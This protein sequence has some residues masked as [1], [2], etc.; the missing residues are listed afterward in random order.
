[1][2]ATILDDTNHIIINVIIVDAVGDLGTV[3]YES[4]HQPNQQFTLEDGVRAPVLPDPIV[5]P[6]AELEN[7]LWEAYRS[8]QGSHLT[9]D[10]SSMYYTER[11]NSPKAQA[12]IDWKDNVWTQYYIDKGT[13]NYSPNFEALGVPPYNYL[14][15]RDEL[16]V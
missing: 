11:N 1:M 7:G 3:A 6:T 10:L 8:Y 14:D 4:W 16:G 5:I 9:D 13:Q 12:I 15:V 2:K